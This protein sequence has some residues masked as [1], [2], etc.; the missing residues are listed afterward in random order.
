MAPETILPKGMTAEQEKKFNDGIKDM[1]NRSFLFKNL[2]DKLESSSNIYYVSVDENIK[3]IAGVQPKE[4]GVSLTFGSAE[5]FEDEAVMNEEF[6]HMYQLENG[7]ANS[8]ETNWEFEA[9]T[10]TMI[11][12]Q[13]FRTDR[14]YDEKYISNTLKKEFGMQDVTKTN[15]QLIKSLKSNFSN[16]NFINL[17]INEANKF[18]K[19]N[20]DFNIGP[21]SYRTDT[22][23]GPTNLQDLINGL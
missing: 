21:K 4:D 18:S 14:S 13:D 12:T 9:K 10:F 6:F 17:Y 20:R 7:K 5:Y 11:S 2:Y 15:K 1:S 16:Q 22:K 19:N 8:S 23:T 3:H